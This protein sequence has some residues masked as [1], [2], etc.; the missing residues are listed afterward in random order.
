M[1]IVLKELNEIVGEKWRSIWAAF[2]IDRMRDSTVAVVL[3]HGDTEKSF[4]S[5]V[6][7]SKYLIDGTLCISNQTLTDILRIRNIHLVQRSIST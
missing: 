5:M 1:E 7:V 6:K 3:G 2:S 4:Y